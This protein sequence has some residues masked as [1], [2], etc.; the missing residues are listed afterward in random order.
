MNIQSA[1]NL[2]NIDGVVS[3]KEIKKAYKAASFKYHPDR[4][5]AGEEIMKAINLAYDYLSSLGDP[6]SMPDGHFSYDFAEELS[7]VLSKLMAI[8]G[9]EIEVCGNWIWISGDTRPHAKTLG[10]DGIG[11]FYASAKKMWY[12]RPAEYKATKRSA[13]LD[14]EKIRSLHGSMSMKSRGQQAIHD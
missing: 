7:G 2:L 5:E 8:P 12:Y 13:S 11:C 1:M 9:L 6:V 14:M 3:Q 10:K 4:N